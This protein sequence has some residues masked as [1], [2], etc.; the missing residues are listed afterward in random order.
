MIPNPAQNVAIARAK[1]AVP[2]I[3]APKPVA[4]KLAQPKLVG[5]P[6]KS[7]GNSAMRNVAQAKMAQPPPAPTLSQLAV[8]AGAPSA[9]QVRAPVVSPVASVIGKGAVVGAPQDVAQ[10]QPPPENANNPYHVVPHGTPIFTHEG[11]YKA[12]YAFFSPYAKPGPYTTALSPAQQQQFNSWVAQYHVPIT[13]DYDMQGYWLANGSKPYNGSTHFPDTFKTPYDTTFSRESKYA[14]ANNPFDWVG[15]QL[16]N[17]HTGK[18]I[19][20]GS[21]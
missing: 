21:D 10:K 18:I 6:M 7:A 14:S 15:Q 12:A 17:I 1:I 20:S 19:F 2:K 11:N 9:P 13:I 3:A 4:P 16:I 5:N 8:A